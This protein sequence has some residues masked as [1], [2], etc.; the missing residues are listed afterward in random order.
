MAP[1]RLVT[2]G[3]GSCVGIAL[4][5]PVSRWGGLAHIMLPDSRQF[6]DHGNRAKFADL[7]I[8]DMLAEML[9]RGARRSRLVARIAG[10][11]QMF[12]S[13]DRHLSF[14]NIGQRN[15]AMVRQTLEGL[16]IP[17][18]GADTGGNFG[19]TMIFDLATGQVHI[20]TI[21]RPLKT[22]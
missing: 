5:D 9:R 6:Q 22:I 10:G 18:A 3:L 13:V 14:L 15:T 17:I 11:A 2:L 7:A 19:R 16:G 21:G 4:Y 8:P 1:E 20:R 12:T